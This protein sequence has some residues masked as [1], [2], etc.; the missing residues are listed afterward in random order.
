MATQTSAFGRGFRPQRGFTAQASIDRSGGDDGNG[1]SM[2]RGPSMMGTQGQ[3][4]APTARQTPNRYQPG[5]SLPVEQLLDRSPD[6]VYSDTGEAVPEGTQLFLPGWQTRGMSGGRYGT[7]RIGSAA[8]AVNS[9]GTPTSQRGRAEKYGEEFAQ[10]PTFAMSELMRK[11]AG[12]LTQDWTRE[13][14]GSLPMTP[15][16]GGTQTQS[17]KSPMGVTQNLA[18]AAEEGLKSMKPEEEET[19]NWMNPMFLPRYLGSKLNLNRYIS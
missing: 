15:P 9:P 13:G 16:S 12:G 14:M 4:A 17:V 1:F 2:R 6:A 7:G 18:E 10:M 5:R 3:V 19:A 11:Y 8:G